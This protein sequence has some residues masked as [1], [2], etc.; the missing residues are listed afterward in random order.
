MVNHNA[1]VQAAGTLR[2][3]ANQLAWI[4]TGRIA[5][6]AP[7]LDPATELAREEVLDAICRQLQSWLDFFSGANS[8]N[9]PA[10]RA[11]AR[12]HAPHDIQSPVEQFGS[13]L[14]ERSFARIESWTVE[15][16]RAIVAE[17]QSMRR[18]ES[19]M[20]GF[21]RWLPQIPG[22]ASTPALRTR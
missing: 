8:L 15:E 4:A 10:A 3:I 5:T 11:I 12:E 6:P 16:R 13:R 7:Q 21:N 14:E 18:L 20:I 17:L 2:R 1:I 9:A 19:L 22:P